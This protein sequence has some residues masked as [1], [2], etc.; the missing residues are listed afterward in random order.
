K[1][2]ERLI[3]RMREGPDGA[4]PSGN[5]VAASVLARLGF[6]HARD[7]FQEAASRA[8]RAYGGQIARHPRA[9][10][11]SLIVTDLLLNGPV[12]LALIGSP[13]PSRA[14]RAEVARHYL[15]NRI[16]A[17]HHPASAPTPHP[18]LAAND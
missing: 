13:E 16:I 8:I 6:H 7:A 14:L 11:K 18:V 15:P 4:V 17:H 1:D 10:A 3:V 5:A 2:H 12:E 9:F